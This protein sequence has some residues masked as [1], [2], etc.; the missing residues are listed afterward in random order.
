[1]EEFGAAADFTIQRASSPTY[2]PATG[3]TTTTPAT[4]TGKGVLL[5]Y[6]DKEI[7]GQRV[8][9]RDRKAFLRHDPTLVPKAGDQ[10]VAAGVTYAVISVRRIELQDVLCGFTCQVRL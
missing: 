8:L 3:A 5:A 7:D 9:E 1:M 4:G 6:S 10:M 2:D